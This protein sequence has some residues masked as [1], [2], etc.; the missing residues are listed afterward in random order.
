M[1]LK[2]VDIIIREATLFFLWEQFYKNVEP[3]LVSKTKNILHAEME[4]NSQLFLI[5]LC[6]PQKWICVLKINKYI[7]LTTIQFKLVRFPD[8]DQKKN[9]Q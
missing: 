8:I 7:R 9:N 2:V 5:V 4:L 6:K 3:Q 1:E